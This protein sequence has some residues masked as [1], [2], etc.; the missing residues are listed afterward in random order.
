[1]WNDFNHAW[2]ATIQAQKELMESGRQLGRSQSRISLEG[3]KKMGDELVR[4]CDGI[5]R[6]GLVDYQYGVWEEQITEGRSIQLYRVFTLGLLTS[7]G[8][9]VLL[10]C[11]ELYGGNDDSAPS[12]GSGR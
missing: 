7:F 2:L 5:E 3:L 6:H 10:E 12:A 4:L 9:T 11:I 1:M 8:Q